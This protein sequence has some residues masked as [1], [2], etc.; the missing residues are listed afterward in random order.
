ML[1]AAQRLYLVSKKGQ[2]HG[3]FDFYDLDLVHAGGGVATIEE[4]LLKRTGD[5]STPEGRG[6]DH[7]KAL[8]AKLRSLAHVPVWKPRTDFLAR[9]P[10]GRLCPPVLAS[11]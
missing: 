7:H 8:A 3:P 10:G 2:A 9:R 11:R 5:A 1:P 4:Y 6:A